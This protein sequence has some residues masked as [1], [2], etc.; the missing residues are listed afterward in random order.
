MAEK[1]HVLVVEDNEHDRA[2]L[3]AHLSDDHYAADYASDGVDAW[4]LLDQHADR[5]DLVLLDRS[6][7][8]MNGLE[9]LGR[10]KRDPRCRTIPV[11]LQTA[12]V[13]RE[14]MIEG[15]RAGAYY[16]LTKPYDA[17]MLHSVI[18]TAAADAAEIRDLQKRLRRGLKVL[19]LLSDAKFSIRTIDEA[20]DLAGV[21]ANACPDPDSTVIGLT[22]LLVNGVEHGNLGITYEE[23]SLLRNCHQWEAEVHRRLGLA[24]NAGKRVDVHF[25]RHGDEIRFHIRDAGQGFEWTRFLDIDPRRAFDTHGR[26]I[27]LARHFSF[28]ALEYRGCGNEVTATVRLADAVA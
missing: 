6:M 18:R 27:L 5:Y 13:G 7:P 20:R 1:T 14:E 3:Q 24:E 10:M 22:E 2:L 28:S 26:G 11:I 8:R 12:H 4:G 19:S 21:L 25:Q 15:I 9:L 23:K 17:E 16:Y